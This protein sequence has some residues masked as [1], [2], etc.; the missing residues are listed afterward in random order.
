MRRPL[1]MSIIAATII[2]AACVGYTAYWYSIAE[3]VR[4]GFQQWVASCRAGGWSVVFREPTVTGFPFRLNLRLQ[5]LVFVGPGDH[6]H[7][8]I[9]DIT[10]AARPWALTDIKLAAPGVYK[11]TNASQAV[12]LTLRQAEGELQIVSGEPKLL[13]FRLT[14][15]DWVQRR[16]DRVRIDEV[17][18]K[19]KNGA[20]HNDGSGD[21]MTG[22]GIALE[23]RNTVLPQSW[24]PPLGKNLDRL[25]IKA[26]LLGRFEPNGILTDVL[27]RWREAGGALELQ[28]FEI[29]WGEMALRGDGTF[30][31][32]ENLQPQ[33]ALA[34]EIDGIEKISEKLVAAGAI[35][36]RIAF[37][38][39]AAN[40]LFSLGGGPARLPISIQR[41]RLYLGPVPLFKVKPVRW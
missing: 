17:T 4:E 8:E 12:T 16:R 13:A 20:P 35:D 40:Q 18:L 29:D 7:G 26:M 27:S 6:W 1:R 32:D 41:Q 14:G 23:A 9:P 5:K 33:S 37:A 21:N 24:N 10:V 11:F 2:L 22:I 3:K 25:S 15:L 31:L 34:V 36:A 19:V 38:A 39:K 28:S 30:A